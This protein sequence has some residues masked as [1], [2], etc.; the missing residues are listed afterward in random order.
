MPEITL[1]WRGGV[2]E[3]LVEVVVDLLDAKIYRINL[4]MQCNLCDASCVVLD[5]TAT[6]LT[7]SKCLYEC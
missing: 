5:G 4:K 6:S 2:F 1:T 7:N 3:H